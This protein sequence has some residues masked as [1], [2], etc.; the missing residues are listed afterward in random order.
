MN[1]KELRKAVAGTAVII[2]VAVCLGLMYLALPESS[3]RVIFGT[4]EPSSDQYL[5]EVEED[6]ADVTYTPP[7]ITEDDIVTTVPGWQ[8]VEVMN[9]DGVRNGNGRTEFNE[10]CGIDIGGTLLVKATEG[11]NYLVE[12]ITEGN[13][14]VYGTPCP[15]GTVFFI[16]IHEFSGMTAAYEK[17][18]ASE[19]NKKEM[20]AGLLGLNTE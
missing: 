5:K 8:W 2:F 20:V 19:K 7:E 12:Y 4:D 9:P 18:V 17:A 11:K 13:K 10:P 6:P 14:V 3:K 1:E 16:P 15:S